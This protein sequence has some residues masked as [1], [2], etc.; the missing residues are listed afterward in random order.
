MV[1]MDDGRGPRGAKGVRGGASPVAPR[2]NLSDFAK[3]PLG[4]YLAGPSFL[5]AWPTPDLCVSALHGVPTRD[6]LEAL[7]RLFALELTAPAVRHAS[8]I[9]AR[10][11]VSVDPGAFSV[12]TRYVQTRST[13]M[14]QFVT[15]L[16]IVRPDG[17]VG[18]LAAG[19][20]ETVPPPYPVESFAD[21][22]SAL[23]WCGVEA[24]TLETTLAVLVAEA[25]E[26]PEIVRDVR[27]AI[28]AR[29]PDASI[30]Q[31][32]RDLALAVRTLQR[33]LGAV[34]TTFRAELAHV[35]VERAKHWLRTT[36]AAITRI[37]YEVGLSTP[38]HLSA[39]FRKAT[40][41]TPSEYRDEAAGR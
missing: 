14:E 15:R 12:L 25:S 18:A 26:L 37:A 22:A 13:D 19:F 29:L 40:G 31:A 34:D 27:R 8:I 17:F 3:N 38:Q 9:D 20:Y 35:Q 5:Y 11:V 21:F 7:T 24:R 23:A 6:D 16:A 39:L 33:K 4:S 28:E 10:R 41:K 36:D 32:A 1:P 2:A 30:D